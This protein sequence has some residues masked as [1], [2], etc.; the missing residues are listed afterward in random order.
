[1]YNIGINKI[2]GFG[3]S[4][5]G[6]HCRLMFHNQL[7]LKHIPPTHTHTPQYLNYWKGIFIVYPVPLRVMEHWKCV[8]KSYVPQQ[9]KNYILGL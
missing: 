7:G 3:P 6:Y 5:F 1:M 8:L 9:L 4:S 2:N